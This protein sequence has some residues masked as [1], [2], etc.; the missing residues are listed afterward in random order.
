[1]EKIK[2]EKGSVIETLL[3]PLYGKKKAHELFPNI[4]TNAEYEKIFSKI[5]YDF[6]EPSKFKA[7]LGAI[8]AATRQ[9]DFVKAATDYLKV[10]PKAPVVSLGCGLD[11]V[12]SLVKNK[13]TKGYNIDFESTINSREN[14]IDT[15]ENEVNIIH[16]ILDT[17]WFE[18]VDFKEDEGAVFIASGVFYYIKKE[19]VKE[20]IQKMAKAFPKGKIVFDATNAKGLKNMLKAWLDPS[21]MG[22]VG[23]YFSLEDEKE[24][25]TWSDDIEKVEKKG[26]MTGY[27]PL[28]SEY[29]FINNMIFKYI[30]RKN[31]SQIIEISFK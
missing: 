25:Y 18:M 1:M 16:D 23:L 19:D 31:L 28:R 11:T 5:D 26:Y 29:G 30:D 3:I 2:I 6:E 10:Y 24:I 12:I 7:K 15:P 13:D 21:N 17:K 20:L 9:L 27:Y 4:F 8:L 22:D 14:L